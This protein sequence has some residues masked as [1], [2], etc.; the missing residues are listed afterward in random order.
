M[1]AIGEHVDVAEANRL[2]VRVVVRTRWTPS[3]DAD[4]VTIAERPHRHAIVARRDRV[5]T[6][7][8]VV[9]GRRVEARTAVR[10]TEQFGIARHLNLQVRRLRHHDVAGQAAI[11][12]DAAS[13]LHERRLGNGH[14]DVGV[15]DLERLGRLPVPAVQMYEPAGTPA[16]SNVPSAFVAAE[17]IT[18]NGA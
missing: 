10:S 7:R 13:E 4:A 12:R 16:I 5:E 8:A 18:A 14:V 17:A 6:E 15:K 2:Q 3:G 9:G 11:E 1:Q